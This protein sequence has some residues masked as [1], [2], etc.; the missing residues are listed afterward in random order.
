MK[1]ML[2]AAG[3]GER[4]G[5]LTATIPKPLLDVGG[6]RLIERQL[7]LLA[8]AGVA[9]V[10]I[11]LSYRGADIRAWVGERTSWGQ[12]VRY[13][14]EGEPPLETGGGI[15]AALPLLGNAPFLLV[16]TDVFTDF[17]FSELVDCSQDN[18]LVLV[19][20]PSHHS[21]DFGLTDD[22]LVTQASPLLT[23]AGIAKLSPALF[24]VRDPG[25]Q[26]LRP[27]LEAAIDRA[28]LAG[29]RY[30]GVWEDVGTPERLTRA[31]RIVTG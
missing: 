22:G 5:A 19:P 28:V 23:Y 18:V 4:M 3:R 15:I 25:R 9:D 14:D 31:R 16:N 29:L 7:R 20:N 12:R 13:S 17:D 21:G 6:E 24:T 11:N 30:D 1:A 27:I 2:L 26:P 10:V 8:Q